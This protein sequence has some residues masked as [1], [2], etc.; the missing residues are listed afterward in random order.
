MRLE[1][2]SPVQPGNSG[3]PVFDHSGDIIGVVVGKLDALK[4]GG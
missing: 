4:I 2:S 3:V 1:I